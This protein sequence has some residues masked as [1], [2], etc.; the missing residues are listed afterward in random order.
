MS[1]AE[2]PKRGGRMPTAVIVIAG[3][4]LG[5]AVL[6]F[7]YGVRAFRMPSGSMQPALYPGDNF[8]VTKWNY[9]YGR[10]SFMPFPGPS[11]RLFA[12]NPQRGDLVVFRPNP[13]P[14]RDFVKRVIGLPGDRM[15]MINGVLHLNGSPVPREDLGEVSFGDEYGG[16]INAQGFRETLPDGAS[17]VVIDRGET[18]LDNT[19]EFVVPV[20]HV[21]LIGDDRDNSA[22]SRVPS[23]VGFVPMDNL[24]GRVAWILKTSPVERLAAE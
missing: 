14:D 12:S 3:M 20:G 13:Q 10:Y 15:Q 6:P 8:V 21:F 9:G 19:R 4:L 11:E 5:L 7:G 17:Y 1:E 18:E 16:T 23:V 22:D 24:I 2:V